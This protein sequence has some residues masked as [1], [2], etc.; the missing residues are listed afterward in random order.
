MNL[1]WSGLEGKESLIPGRG[2]IP[3]RLFLKNF[4]L[5]GFV[6]IFLGKESWNVFVTNC[7]F[8]APPAWSSLHKVQVVTNKV[9]HT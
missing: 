1:I 4:V 2:I 9:R 3:I 8:L 6:L 7:Q 5:P